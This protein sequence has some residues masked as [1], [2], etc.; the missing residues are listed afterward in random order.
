MRVNSNA[1]LC[2]SATSDRRQGLRR[3]GEPFESS[4]CDVPLLMPRFKSDNKEAQEA[5]EASAIHFSR[6]WQ[7]PRFE[8]RKAKNQDS[9]NKGFWSQGCIWSGSDPTTKFEA[10]LSIHQLQTL[11]S[12]QSSHNLWKAVY[13]FDPTKN[14]MFRSQMFYVTRP[15]TLMSK[16]FLRELAQQTSQIF[17]VEKFEK[18]N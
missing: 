6:K 15:R 9:N 7:H 4:E 12:K 13:H 5:G 11:Y 14:S 10:K 3:E 16:I 1:C 8:Q 17:R 18:L 2:W